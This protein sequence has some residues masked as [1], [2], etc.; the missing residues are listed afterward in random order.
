M[1][2]AP[3]DT[4]VDERL[5]ELEA[6][7][8]RLDRIR[9]LRKKADIITRCAARDLDGQAVHLGRLGTRILATLDALAA[10]IPFPVDEAAAAKAALALPR[11]APSPGRQ[12]RVSFNRR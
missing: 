3:P 6:Q 5:A 4:A 11:R 10:A 7:L 9:L 1:D 2:P 8:D 12:S